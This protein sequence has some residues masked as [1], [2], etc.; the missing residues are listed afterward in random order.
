MMG[1]LS[2]ISSKQ[3]VTLACLHTMV[4]VSNAEGTKPWH[5]LPIYTSL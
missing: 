5:H 4:I 1:D 2:G 3:T